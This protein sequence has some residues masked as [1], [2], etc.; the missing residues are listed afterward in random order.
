[1]ARLRA[2]LAG[3]AALTVAALPAIPASAA[4]ADPAAVASA[5]V[6]VSIVL[7]LSVSV[8][9]GTLVPAEALAA[10]TA[11]DGFLSVELDATINRGV[12]YAIDPMLLASIRVLGTTAPA[13]ATQW[14]SRLESA[15]NAT[16]A[17]AWADSDITAPLQAGR[18]EVV[19]LGSL[20]YAIDPALFAPP[21]DD[22][23][24]TTTPE[25]GPTPAPPA[26]PSSPELTA[27]NYSMPS[28][29]W[30]LA[31]TATGKDVTRIRKSG[32][33]TV[34]L[35]SENVERSHDFT[36]IARAKRTDVVVTDDASTELFAAALAAED[37][38]A[39]DR[40]IDGLTSSVAARSLQAGGGSLVIALDR[41]APVPAGRLAETIEGLADTEDVSIVGLPAIALDDGPS[42]TIIDRP[43]NAA[44]ISRVRDMLSAERL[45]ARFATVADEPQLISGERRARL[46][47]SLSPGADDHGGGW[48]HAAED[49]LD[50]SE[51]LRASVHLVRSSPIALLADRGSIP[52]TVRNELQVPVTV[53]IEVR[54]MRPLIAVE[55]ER[56]EVTIEPE[57]QAQGSVPVESISNGVVELSVSISSDRDVTVGPTA[58]VRT[59]VQAGWEGPVTVTLAILLLL[60]FVLGIVRAVIRRRAARSAGDEA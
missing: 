45:D 25:P 14:L 24:P 48:W 58:H 49:F 10:A 7:P 9:T 16:F 23:D 59:R 41:S 46:L 53:N 13:S 57:S 35:S 34:L 60:V 42:A 22:A 50:E 6:D 27:W 33:S 37:D 56:V 8:S 28:V 30:P 11:P 40:A 21:T 19:P 2:A 51:A 54:P 15:T 32:F 12:T 43:Q 31:G 3:V 17:L 26:V 38:D 47:V 4:D 1:M 18:D 44:R 20:D 39:F 36:A 52:V 55:D 5:P 29:A